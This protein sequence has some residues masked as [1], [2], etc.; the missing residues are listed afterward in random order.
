MELGASCKIQYSGAEWRPISQH[1]TPRKSGPP[2][3]S[4]TPTLF[5]GKDFRQA[6]CTLRGNQMVQIT[7]KPEVWPHTSLCWETGPH[8]L[9]P[10]SLS[11][12]SCVMGTKVL[13]TPRWGQ[14]WNGPPCL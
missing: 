11:F 14:G 13:P 1:Q 6:G 3:P 8:P 12:F 5:L 4:N 10:L 2:A 7:Q 9:S